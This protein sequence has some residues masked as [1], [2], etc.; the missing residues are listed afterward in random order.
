MRSS[1]IWGIFKAEVVLAEADNTDRGN[2]N[3]YI[4]REPNSMIVLLFIYCFIIY[5][6]IDLFVFSSLFHK[7][8]ELAKRH[9]GL[10]S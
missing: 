1:R 2:N 3:S 8:H 7:P 4:L 5:F 6:I 9:S 10:Q